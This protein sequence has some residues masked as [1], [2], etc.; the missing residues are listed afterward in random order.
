MIRALIFNAYGTLIDWEKGFSF[1]AV[2]I[3]KGRVE[4]LSPAPLWKSWQH[5][6]LNK[7]S[8]EKYQPFRTIAAR[9]F[10]EALTAC[11]L[12]LQQG[13]GDKLAL[14]I[15]TWKTFPD[16]IPVLRGLRG[17]I[18]LHIFSNT[19]DELLNAHILTLGLSLDGNMTGTR[20]KTYKPSPLFYQKAFDFLKID[21]A[22]SLYVSASPQD[23]DAAASQGLQTAW[24]RRHELVSAPSKKPGFILKS[25]NSIEEMPDLVKTRSYAAP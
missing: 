9:S 10:E 12:P 23:L 4:T 18:S 3:L 20:A 19:D 1:A 15:P 7:T 25:L 5:H 22:A 11:G 14:R 21:P 17:K 13:D 8:S 2:E 6:V 24:V 16:V